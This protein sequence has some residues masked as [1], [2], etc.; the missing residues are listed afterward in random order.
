[1]PRFTTTG[2]GDMH[3]GER[4]NAFWTGV[5]DGSTVGVRLR[6]RIAATAGM[7]LFAGGFLVAI[8]YGAIVLS[9]L[10]AALIVIVTLAFAAAWPQLERV[11]GA[12]LGRLRRQILTTAAALPPLCRQTWSRA[13]PRIRSVYQSGVRT[14]ATASRRAVAFTRRAVAT[15]PPLWRQTRLRAEPRVR[16]V[17][18]L[19][20]R[21]G[22]SANRWALEAAQ[23]TTVWIA[24]RARHTDPRR[25]ALGLN[26]AGAQYRRDG[27][28]DHAVDCHRRALEIFRALDDRKAVALTQSN[29]ALALSHAG[30]DNWAIGLFEEAAATL[31]EL[32]DAEHEAQIIANL[33]LAHRR[34]GRR[35]EGD[36]VLELALSKLPPASN[37][38]QAIEAELRRA[39]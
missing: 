14:G 15:L 7:G 10:A 13:E 4:V 28:Y 19:C 36:S 9:A 8:G 39:S 1:M 5:R 35:E 16:G 29:L 20:I 32:G 37:E 6:R 12:A 21:T 30:D 25:H 34:H 33:G 38:Y 2:V 17:Y 31:R 24:S 3:L 18:R 23:G 27:L 26:A 22:A 11:L